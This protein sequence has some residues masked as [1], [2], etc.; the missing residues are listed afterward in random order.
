MRCFTANS[1]EPVNSNGAAKPLLRRKLSHGGL[2]V[3]LHQRANGL[4]RL[5]HQLQ[6]EKADLAGEGSWMDANRTCQLLAR[7]PQKQHTRWYGSQGLKPPTLRRVTALSPTDP[8]ISHLSL[9]EGC[10]IHGGRLGLGIEDRVAAAHV[11]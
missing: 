3:A 6:T 10:Q 8:G 9:G 2:L 1:F 5:V 11:G 7:P 4:R